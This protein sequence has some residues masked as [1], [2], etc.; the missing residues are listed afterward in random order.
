MTANYCTAKEEEPQKVICVCRAAWIETRGCRWRGLEAT[1]V[2]IAI[3]MTKRRGSRRGWPMVE[4]SLGCCPGSLTLLG[5]L[6]YCLPP[7]LLCALESQFHSVRR[8]LHDSFSSSFLFVS[9]ILF[10]IIPRKCKNNKMSMY[11][12]TIRYVSTNTDINRYKNK[13]SM[14][15]DTTS[16]FI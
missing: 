1:A 6:G 7:P 3:P 10:F 12:E 11:I 9:I 8:F 5:P 15:K 2:A 14:F 4:V 16:T 13:T